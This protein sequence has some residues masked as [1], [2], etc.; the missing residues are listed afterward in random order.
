MKKFEHALDVTPLKD[1][2]NWKVLEDFYYETDVLLAGPRH[3]RVVINKGFKTDFASFPRFLWTPI[4]GPAEGR[5]RKAAVV[6]DKLYRT[7]GLATRQE[8]D[9][10]LFEAMGVCGT[11]WVT[12]Y[13]IWLGV[14]LFGWTSY[15]GGL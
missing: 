6:H 2:T 15:K 9:A 12:K 14:R 10:V 8:A 11:N 3:H 4:G 5:Y 7:T 13:E 1:G